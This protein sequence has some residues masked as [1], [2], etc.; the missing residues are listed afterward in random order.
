[1]NGMSRGM[2]Q[3]D[4]WRGGSKEAQGRPR[5]ME[6]CTYTVE[7]LRRLNENIIAYIPMNI[8]C[9]IFKAYYSIPLCLNC[10]YI[11]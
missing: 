8:Q 5:M 7:E 3:S 4:D 9:N 10:M 6:R 11:Q 2:V 1:M